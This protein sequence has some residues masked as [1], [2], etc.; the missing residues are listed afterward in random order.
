M[1]QERLI[2]SP[3]HTSCAAGLPPYHHVLPGCPHTPTSLHGRPATANLCAQ[4]VRQP[5][6]ANSISTALCSSVGPPL[7]LLPP[8]EPKRALASAQHGSRLVSRPSNSWSRG[9]LGAGEGVIAPAAP[10]PPAAQCLHSLRATSTTPSLTNT[11]FAVALPYARWRRRE[12]HTVMRSS[13]AAAAPAPAATAAP[14]RCLWP[15]CGEPEE[16]APTSTRDRTS[17]AERAAW[18]GGLGGAIKGRAAGCWGVGGCTGLGCMHAA[19]VDKASEG[20]AALLAL[21]RG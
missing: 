14:A 15:T 5:P 12:T 9:R 21:L 10:D 2:P 1:R 6:T 8:S 20:V 7:P 17:A 4:A 13:A 3:A 18:P 11:C 16:E 19:G